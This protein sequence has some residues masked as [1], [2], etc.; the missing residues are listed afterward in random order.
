MIEF[1]TQLFTG[2]WILGSYV[3]VGLFGF[4]AGWACKSLQWP[5]RSEQLTAENQKL[6]G[7]LQE[8]VYATVPR[9]P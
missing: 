9:K 8:T 5:N 6:R 3:T 1:I 2:T 4:G 7:L